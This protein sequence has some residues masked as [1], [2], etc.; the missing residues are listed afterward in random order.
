MKLYD[1]LDVS[2]EETIFGLST[3]KADSVGAES[4]HGA[5]GEPLRS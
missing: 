5:R 1:G 3:P 2:L 4:W